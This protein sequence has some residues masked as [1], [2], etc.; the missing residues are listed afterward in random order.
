MKNRNAGRRGPVAHAKGTAARCTGHNVTVRVIAL[1]ASVL[2]IV[3]VVVALWRASCATTALPTVDPF[4]GWSASLSLPLIDLADVMAMP[5]GTLRA[6]AH[7]TRVPVL[8]RFAVPTPWDR[9]ADAWA[10]SLEWDRH[11]FRPAE[12]RH[13]WRCRM[14][15]AR[16]NRALGQYPSSRGV[17]PAQT[18]REIVRAHVEAY[19]KSLGVDD[20]TWLRRPVAFSHYIARQWLADHPGMVDLVAATAAVLDV[21]SAPHGA[22][23]DLKIWLNGPGYCTGTHDDPL[24]NLSINVCG[25]KR[26]LL[27]PPSDRDCFYPTD[28]LETTGVQRYHVRNPFVDVGAINSD[29]GDALFPRLAD[30][31][32]VEVDVAAGHVLVVPRRWIHFVATTEPSVS[33]TVNMPSRHYSR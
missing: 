18:M 2:A 16:P 8:V 4:G 27:A 32:M 1:I 15:D 7:R 12:V 33:F 30:A 14:R 24:D 13:I 31:R 5:G 20:G 26:W 6:L 19:S 3:L 23:R 9:D 21:G 11:P 17:D 28:R 25:R 29:T 22:Y 10:R